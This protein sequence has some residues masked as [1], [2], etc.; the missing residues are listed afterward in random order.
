MTKVDFRVTIR[1]DIA[2]LCPF[3]EQELE[4]VYAK[5]KGW[6][7]LTGKNVIYFCPHCLKVLG[8]GQSRMA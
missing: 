1:E 5:T 4:E 2:P 6:G 8:F 7:L 3:C